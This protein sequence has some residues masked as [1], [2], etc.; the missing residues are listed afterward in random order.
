MG[1]HALVSSNVSA[2][3]ETRLHDMPLGLLFL[4]DFSLPCDEVPFF[5]FVKHRR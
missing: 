5:S 1:K 3:S 2:V 4:K